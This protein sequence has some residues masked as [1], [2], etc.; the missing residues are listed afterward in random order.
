MS[1]RRPQYLK[2]NFTGIS[3]A[4]RKYCYPRPEFVVLQQP[5]LLVP[6]PPK[7]PTR[8]NPRLQ[9]KA[10]SALLETESFAIQTCVDY[11]QPATGGGARIKRTENPRI[12]VRKSLTSGLP[13]RV[14]SSIVTWISPPPHL[15]LR[16]VQLVIRQ[17]TSQMCNHQLLE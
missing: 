4:S 11:L 1:T 16:S 6:D 17:T 12:I 5:R 7:N 10:T 14:L 15:P 3:F 8:T 2:F 9:P 13:S